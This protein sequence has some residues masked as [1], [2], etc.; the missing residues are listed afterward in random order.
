MGKVQ[1]VNTIL[2]SIYV[3]WWY[4]FILSKAIIREINKR[5][6]VFVW[7]GGTKGKKGGVIVWEKICRPK[8]EGR[9]G[10]KD[11]DIWNKAAVGKLI[12]EL[13]IVKN[14][15]WAVWVSKNELKQLSF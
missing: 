10:I 11:L 12:W 2:R 3:Y 9:L 13:L 4:M 7:A 5:C 8:S 14:F 1:L 15:V 6:R